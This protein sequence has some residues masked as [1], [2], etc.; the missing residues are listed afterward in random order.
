MTSYN[1]RSLFRNKTVKLYKKILAGEIKKF[2]KKYWEEVNREDAYYCSIYFIEKVLKLFDEDVYKIT[3]KHFNTYMLGEMLDEIYDGKVFNVI[4]ELYPNKY[5]LWRFR[6]S[7]GYWTKETLINALKS[8]VDNNNWSR[9]DLIREYGIQ[10]IRDMGLSYP[11]KK[12]YNYNIYELLDDAYPGEYEMWELRKV[13]NN[14]WNRENARIATMWLVE[15]LEWS[16]ES[17]KRNMTKNVFIE[18]GLGGMLKIVYNN[19][20]FAAIIDAYPGEYERF[21]IAISKGYWTE[22]TCAEAVRFMIE[23]GLFFTKEDVRLKLS[24]QHFQ[25][26]R[27]IYAVKKVYNGD[28]YLAVDK[29]YPGEYKRSDLKLLRFREKRVNDLVKY[30]YEY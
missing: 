13:A 30:I 2:P 9:D 8:I 15:K 28:F 18:Y 23:N 4:N 16:R 1:K 22:E 17:I 6:V 27:L 25:E 3:K 26:Y 24:R 7:K 11:M 10:F 20:V 29:A 5:Y 21:E 19:S 12:I 14:Y